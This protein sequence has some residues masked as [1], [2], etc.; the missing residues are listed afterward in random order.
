M[1]ELTDAGK[2]ILSRLYYAHG[3]ARQDEVRSE[4]ASLPESDLLQLV[5]T[6]RMDV[7]VAER[8]AAQRLSDLR[9]LLDQLVARRYALAA[10]RDALVQSL[11][12]IDVGEGVTVAAAPVMR[13][14]MD[15]L[16]EKA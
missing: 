14:A 9:T 3:T 13:R 16:G 15:L 4:V 7:A 2:T 6:C 5:T 1:P 12:V 10:V 11:T 8:S